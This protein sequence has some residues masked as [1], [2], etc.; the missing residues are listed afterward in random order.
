MGITI[1][2]RNDLSPRFAGR[3]QRAIPLQS[4]HDAIVCDL[5]IQDIHRQHIARL[6]AVYAERA[7]GGI[8]MGEIQIVFMIRFGFDP[9]TKAILC[10]KS[11]NIPACSMSRRRARFYDTFRSFPSFIQS[12]SFHL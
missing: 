4:H 2:D 5:N 7:C 1:Y 8:R 10:D 11:H 12:C 9:V 3:S 6:C